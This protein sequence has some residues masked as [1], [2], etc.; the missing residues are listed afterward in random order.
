MSLQNLWNNTATAN[1]AT[2]FSQSVKIDIDKYKSSLEMY[3]EIDKCMSYLLE[4]SNFHN[5]CSSISFF[6]QFIFFTILLE[7]KSGK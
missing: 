1:N 4:A 7:G 2:K 6:T 3:N 5:H